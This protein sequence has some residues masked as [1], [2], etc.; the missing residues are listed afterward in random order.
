MVLRAEENSKSDEHGELHAE[1]NSNLT[2][3]TKQIP[4]RR[5]DLAMPEEED[6]KDGE[7]IEKVKKKGKKEKKG[8]K[9]EKK[10]KKDKKDK[11]SHLP[12]CLISV[13]FG[14]SEEEEGEE[15]KQEKEKE[16]ILFIFL[17]IVLQLIVR[18]ISS[19]KEEKKRNEAE[20]D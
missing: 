6:G 7:E 17:F 16:K 10:D 12:I 5:R 14:C 13:L 9:T 20:T 2:E 4:W 8:G 19:A 18:L 3:A 15:E 1:P 11:A